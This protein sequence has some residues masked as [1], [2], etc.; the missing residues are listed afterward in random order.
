[1]MAVV[2]DISPKG[3]SLRL[4]WS[5]ES[6]WQQRLQRD[7]QVASRNQSTEQQAITETLM[8]RAREGGAL[9]FALTGS[10]ARARRTAIS[11]LDYHV[12]GK[13]PR[14]ND[15]PDDVDVYATDLAGFWRKLNEGD[16]F[17]QW[18]LRY[19]CV[20]FDEGV[21]HQ[22]MKHL[23]SENLWPSPSLKFARLAEHIRLA[24]RLISMGDRDAAQDQ[25]RATLTSVSRGLLLDSRVF[26]LARAELPQQL[27]A[28][29]LPELGRA[30][31]RSIADELTLA[32]LSEAL[33]L[34]DGSAPIEALAS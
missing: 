17:V 30:L 31:Q 29:E 20:L 14:H 10:T 9:A 2:H 21:F 1:M 19:G 5:D 34:V 7:Q 16:D 24:R 32:Q 26:P 23:V 15:L 8:A 27:R 12:V 22:G 3:W 13:R 18:T 25:V 28:A 6:V 33:D 4:D 11:D